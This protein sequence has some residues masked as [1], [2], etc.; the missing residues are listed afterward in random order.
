MAIE[1]GTYIKLSY[2]G[3]V[4]GV[5]FDTTDAEVAKT[6]EIY[7]ENAMYGPATVKVGAGH[8]LP[9]VDED[10]AGKEVGKEYTLVIP[11]AKAFG[12]HKSEEMKAFDKK[13]FDKK[14]EMYERVKIEGR[15]GVVINKV[16]SRYIVDFNHPLAG[17]DIS[18]VYTI[19]SVVEDGI[20]KL[21]GMIKLLT[22]R[23]MKVTAEDK[24][25]ISIEVPAMMSMYNQNWLMTQYM[26]SQ[27]AFAIFADIE[28]VKFI[29][30]FPRPT[31]KTES[32]EEQAAE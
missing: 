30:S 10:L 15:D 11:A 5:P 12:E 9:G 26:V 14:P 1:N 4:N 8:V 28:N 18:Y 27:E 3:S 19:E 31:I 29:E 24:T 25:F 22:G 7:R 20:E 13:A 32:A 2:T 6:A 17:Q 16:G 23:D 21:T